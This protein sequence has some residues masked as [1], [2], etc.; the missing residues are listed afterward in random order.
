MDGEDYG[1]WSLEGNHVI[2]VRHKNLLAAC[3]EM[4]FLRL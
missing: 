4:R 2:A 1:V 3:G